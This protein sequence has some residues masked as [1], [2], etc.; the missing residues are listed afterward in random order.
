MWLGPVVV[1]A[2]WSTSVV[3]RALCH[4]W[5]QGLYK[6]GRPSSSLSFFPSFSKLF[7]FPF[8]YFSSEHSGLLLLNN[9]LFLSC[10]DTSVAIFFSLFSWKSSPLIMPMLETLIRLYES[11]KWAPLEPI[12]K[13]YKWKNMKSVTDRSKKVLDNNTITSQSKQNYQKIKNINYCCYISYRHKSKF[14]L[15]IFYMSIIYRH[16]NKFLLYIFY[17]SIISFSWA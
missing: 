13:W 10:C 3:P 1:E 7:P 16:K 4:A 11:F 17:I 9:W 15:Y 12:K 14:L 8:Y 6:K 2:I 5:T